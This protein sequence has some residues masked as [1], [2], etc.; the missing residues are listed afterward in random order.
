M[1]T[2]MI[3]QLG[4]TG[5]RPIDPE[6]PEWT[7]ED[8]LEA[9]QFGLP[10]DLERLYEAERQISLIIETVRKQEKAIKDLRGMVFLAMKKKKN[11]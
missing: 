4:P 1:T 3:T 6:N 11:G 9:Q 10:I 7:K 2:N 8:I 5:T